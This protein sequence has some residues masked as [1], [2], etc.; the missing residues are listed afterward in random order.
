M[1]LK[2]SFI[3]CPCGAHANEMSPHIYRKGDSMEINLRC[4]CG[5]VHVC[6]VPLLNFK[7]TKHY[8]IKEKNK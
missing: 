3:G 2:N 4:G 1:V 6:T 8:N 7:E 5:E